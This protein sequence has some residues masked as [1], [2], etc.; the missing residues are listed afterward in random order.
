MSLALR[1]QAIPQLVT[2]TWTMVSVLLTGNTANLIHLSLVPNYKLLAAS[3]EI[4]HRYL[5]I[6]YSHSQWHW[7]EW[8]SISDRMQHLSVIGANSYVT[9]VNYILMHW[10]QFQE[11]RFQKA[12][13]AVPMC[14]GNNLKS[15]LIGNARDSYSG[16]TRFERRSRQ[17]LPWLRSFLVSLRLSR[18]IPGQYLHSAQIASSQIRN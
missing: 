6:R 16:V 10:N 8:Q 14:L 15:S 5:K 3:I 13:G 12:V 11:C 1:L 7:V 2:E 9:E 4:N 17:R 18:Q